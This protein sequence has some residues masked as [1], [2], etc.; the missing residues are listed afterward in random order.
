MTSS[1]TRRLWLLIAF[2][3]A[4]DQATKHWA[5]NRLSNART[6]DLI[7][8]LR[9]N[10]AFNKGMAFSQATGAGPIIGALAFVVII[11][12]VLWLRRNA[13]G[14]AGVAAGLIVGGATGNLIDRL[15]RGDAWLR[16]A[17]V[18]FIDLQWWP[19]FNIADAAISTGAVLMIVASVRAS[20]ST[21]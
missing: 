14:L 6:I 10:L 7:G 11:V 16:G 9:F 4:A 2:I 8:S 19:I 13:Q 1:A 17:V 15:L 18:D 21:S 12:I 5:L 3:V 20:K